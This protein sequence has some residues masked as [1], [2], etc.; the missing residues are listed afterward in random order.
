VV[1]PGGLTVVTSL[2][3]VEPMIPAS[4]FTQADI[5][6]E[7][8]Q[9]AIRAGFFVD[10]LTFKDSPAM[11]ATEV[12]ERKQLMLQFMSPTMGRI[13]SDFLDPLI[14]NTV[15]MLMRQGQLK[16][17]P[18]SLV[19][20]ELDIEYTGPLPRAQKAEIAAGIERWLMDIANLAEIF[21]EMLDIP[22]LDQVVRTLQELNGVPA[23]LAR[24]KDEVKK[25]RKDREEAQAE[26]AE[27]AKLQ[28]GG[29][30]MQA[31]GEG[32]DA[33]TKSAGLMEAVG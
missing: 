1:S 4:N 18:E 24:T 3:E 8:L 16:D 13:K 26:A 31:A 6:R 9:A 20:V 7:R 2:D 15:M 30:A 29:E 32:A 5:E 19:G 33:I 11:T 10:Q 12:L 25:V 14:K 27:I 22:D 17:L 23:K 28:A 21:P